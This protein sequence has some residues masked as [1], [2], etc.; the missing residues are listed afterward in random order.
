MPQNLETTIVGKKSETDDSNDEAVGADPDARDLLVWEPVSS[1]CYWVTILLLA[2]AGSYLIRWRF[3]H[4]GFYAGPVHDPWGITT[5]PWLVLPVAPI[6]VILTLGLA[7]WCALRGQ[8]AWKM[9]MT[10]GSLIIVLA[11]GRLLEI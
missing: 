10:A 6:G 5:P 1:L 9:L 4:S 2:I 3:T 7:A 11:C 8:R